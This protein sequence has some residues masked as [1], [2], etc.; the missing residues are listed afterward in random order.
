MNTA[1]RLHPPAPSDVPADPDQRLEWIKYQLRLRGSSLSAVAREQDVTRQA[2]RT[3][4]VRPYPRMERAI[5]ATLGVGPELLWP[6]RYDRHGRR[7]IQMGRPRNSVVKD[8]A[9]RRARNG[10]Q[11]VVA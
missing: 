8:T 7:T 5:A 1:T 2:A 10:V 6:E 3:A 11:Q 4:L 9:K